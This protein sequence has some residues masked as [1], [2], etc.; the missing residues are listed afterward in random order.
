MQQRSKVPV[1]LPNQSRQRPELGTELQ[2]PGH[3]GG[4]G[5]FWNQTA[6]Q[7]QVGFEVHPTRV[8]SRLVHVF[9]SPDFRVNHEFLEVLTFQPRKPG[10]L[11]GCTAKC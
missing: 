6:N 1:A 2:T 11:T 8:W 3:K 10:R 5:C 7:K 4:L 9:T